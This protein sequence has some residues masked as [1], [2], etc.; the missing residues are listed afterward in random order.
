MPYQLSYEGD[1]NFDITKYFH[2]YLFKLTLE[3]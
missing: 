1:L 2:Y 3:F